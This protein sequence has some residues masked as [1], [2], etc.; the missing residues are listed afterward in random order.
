MATTA[1]V[2]LPDEALLSKYRAVRS[3][4]RTVIVVFAIIIGAWI[5]LGY[6]K[7]N[8]PVFIATVAM[9]VFVVLSQSGV[10]GALGAEVRKR[11]LHPTPSSR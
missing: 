9:G 2:D 3:I 4:Q 5:L 10:S 8:L 6:W 11:G 1:V 7:T